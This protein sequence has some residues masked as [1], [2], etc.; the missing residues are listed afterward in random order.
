MAVKH[1]HNSW[2]NDENGPLTRCHDGAWACLATGDYGGVSPSW[3]WCVMGDLEHAYRENAE[4]KKRVAE[5]EAKA[6]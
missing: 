1:D 6:S 2:L 3:M 5:L 4:L